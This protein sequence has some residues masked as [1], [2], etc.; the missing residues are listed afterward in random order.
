MIEIH[1]T[2]YLQNDA[3]LVA[4]FGNIGKIYAIQAPAG[5]TMPWLIVEAAGGSRT[6][7][8][9]NRINERN[10]IRVSV[11]VGPTHILKGRQAIE[12]A[13]YLVENYRGDMYDSE[14]V[15]ITCSAIRGWAGMTGAYR[16]QFDAICEFVEPL[17]KRP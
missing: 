9:S 12:R 17:V 10:T 8:G 3:T 2:Q 13:K 16:Y 5:A 15:H 4:F 11:D 14:D 6:Q 7:I 1:I